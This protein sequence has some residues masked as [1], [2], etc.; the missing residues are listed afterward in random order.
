[1]TENLMILFEDEFQVKKRWF[2]SCEEIIVKTLTRSKES[3][4]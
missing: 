1:M 4:G 3:V 2:F